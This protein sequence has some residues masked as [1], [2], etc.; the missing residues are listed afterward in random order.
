[1]RGAPDIPTAASYGVGVHPDL[2]H[3][4][5]TVELRR[6]GRY[7]LREQIG[8]GGMGVVYK[9]V[10][11]DGRVVAVKLLRPHVAG[12]AESRARFARE[13]QALARVRG[14]HV[15]QVLDADVA[16]ATPYLVTDFVD[17]PSLQETVAHEGPLEGADL[18]DLAG[19]LADAL[20]SIHGAGV[21]HRDLKPGNVL[22]Q[23]GLAVVIDFGIAQIADD[24]RLTMPGTV[25]GTP[26]YVAPELLNGGEVT[27]A[28]DIHSWAATVTYAATGRPPFGQG[29]L[30]AVAYRV[31]QDEPDLDGCPDWLLPVLRRCFAKDPVARPSAHELLH[32]LETGEPPPER[33]VTVTTDAHPTVP[34]RLRLPT[35]PESGDDAG[36]SEGSGVAATATYGDG[37]H[38]GGYPDRIASS[39]EPAVEASRI[40]ADAAHSHPAASYPAD[41]YPA[42]GDAA[43]H[44]ADLHPANGS[45]TDAGPVDGTAVDRASRPD[46]RRAHQVVL[47]LAF[48]TLAG[49]AAVVPA[50]AALGLVAWLVLAR[51]V[52]RSARL[53][54]RRRA[55]RGRR[56]TDLLAATMALPWHLVRGALVTALTLPFAVIGAGI[57][58]GLVVLFF[59]AGALSPRVD[60]VLGAAALATATLAWWGIEGE[61]VRRGSRH[62]LTRALRPRWAP[63]TAAGVLVVLTLL[64]LTAASTEP[65]WWWPLEGSWSWFGWPG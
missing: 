11:P 39:A 58:A 28:A 63:A 30:E 38:P 56:R 4:A 21:V 59:Y 52:D 44:P 35:Q 55:A 54:R 46:W 43:A 48:V 3:D 15:A 16:A 9:A 62:M 29:P 5:P 26:G 17:G 53:V 13:A 22:L 41:G 60:V 24:T 19:D 51:T 7:V 20:C 57:L 25:Y 45:P 14:E 6:L 33:T 23:D 2:A 64:A 40:D 49:L 42:D 47:V 34:I 8:E 27:P 61:G 18:A 36:W 12:D 32:W 10:D 65:V 50:V 31:L 1:M 37:H